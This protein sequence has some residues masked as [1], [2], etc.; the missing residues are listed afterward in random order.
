MIT[1]KEVEK[2]INSML[3][4]LRAP[5]TYLDNDDPTLFTTFVEVTK[6]SIGDEKLHGVYKEMLNQLTEKGGEKGLTLV[7]QVEEKI[8][9][10][11]FATKNNLTAEVGRMGVFG[12][13]SRAF[14]NNYETISNILSDV[15]KQNN[16]NVT[17]DYTAGITKLIEN[18]QSSLAGQELKT[19]SGLILTA[20][21]KDLKELN[22]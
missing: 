3:A 11:G 8:A 18:S 17:G 10:G 5:E 12:Q 21:T 22:I 19:S 6:Y 20:S 9:F 14:W 15:T 13:D 2:N 7:Q 16:Q 1:F 4:M